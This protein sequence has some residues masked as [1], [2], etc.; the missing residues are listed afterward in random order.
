VN[1]QAKITARQL[2]PDQID[3]L[4]DRF[5]EF[6]AAQTGH[7]DYAQLAFVAEINGAAVG[8][9]AGYTW[10]GYCE[11]RQLWVDQAHRGKGLGSELITSAIDEARSRGCGAIFLFTFSF[12][13][14]GFYARFGFER[15]CE[16]RE[17]PRGHTDI[18]MRLDLTKPL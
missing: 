7:R 17:K 4:E 16:L 10:G 6:N 9:V 12:Q 2:S 1:Q 8:A 3:A 13:A 15:T 5:Y 14:P 18:L 11:L